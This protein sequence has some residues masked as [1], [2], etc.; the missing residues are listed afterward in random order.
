MRLFQILW[1]KSMTSFGSL[2]SQVKVIFIHET[3]SFPYRYPKILK[4]LLSGRLDERLFYDT[5]FLELLNSSNEF[6]A[7]HPAG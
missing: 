6:P 7:Q 2:M 4:T 3:I 1:R 5:Y